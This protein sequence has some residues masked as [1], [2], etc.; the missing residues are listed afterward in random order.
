MINCVVLSDMQP[1]VLT[2]KLN[3]G[4]EKL[5]VDYGA[6]HYGDTYVVEIVNPVEYASYVEFGHRTRNHKGGIAGRFMMTIAEQELQS[7]A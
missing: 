3:I 7:I 1:N 5:F 4:T 2:R 6:N